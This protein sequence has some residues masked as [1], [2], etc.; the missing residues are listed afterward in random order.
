MPTFACTRNRRIIGA[1]K[2]VPGTKGRLLNGSKDMNTESIMELEG[3]LTEALRCV[4]VQ[5][6]RPQPLTIPHLEEI[7][8][9]SRTNYQHLGGSLFVSHSLKIT[10]AEVEQKVLDLIRRELADHIREDKILSATTAFASG[11]TD[12]SPIELILRNLIVRAI[13]DGPENAAQAF[14]DCTTKSSCTFYQFFLLTGVTV[15]E[16]VEVF[17]GISLIPLPRSVSELPPFLPNV[18][19]RPDRFHTVGIRDFLGKTLLRIEYEISPIFHKPGHNYTLESD[20][21]E[22][23]TISQK[24]QEIADVN[25]DVLR[26]ALSVASRSSVNEVLTWTCLLDYE[27]FDLT[28]RMRIGGDSFSAYHRVEDIDEPGELNISQLETIKTIY[29]GLLQ[30]PNE[31][32]EK[33]RIPISRWVQSME[34]KDQIDQIIDF[35]IALDALYVPNDIQGEVTFRFAL[36]AAWHQG[37][38][39]NERQCLME[40]FKLIYR[41]RSKAVHDGK[42]GKSTTKAIKAMFGG[43][44][45]FIDRAQDLCWAG[46]NKVIEDGDTPS[47]QNLVMGGDDH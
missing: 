34:D 38:D 27:I 43:V 8:Q 25:V 22:H 31:T 46:V 13:V 45:E 33:L 39:K 37:R 44:P 28:S 42:L 10:Q 19:P 30:L 35:G 14:A 40:E 36:H 2:T 32:W 16:Q 15:P 6:R 20:P 29:S 41:A 23:F 7:L 26:Q 12:S 1:S 9:K 24:G 3:L 21:V 47:W 18:R 5:S 4:E 17:D 11:A